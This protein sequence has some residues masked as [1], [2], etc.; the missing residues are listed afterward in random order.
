MT[1][2]GE[3]P[4]WPRLDKRTGDKPQNRR[5]A[6]TSKA[7]AAGRP[8]AS[9]R[10]VKLGRD[11]RIATAHATFSV[12]RAAAAGAEQRVVV[13]AR[14][15]EKADAAGLQAVLAGR[16]EIVRAGKD[17]AWSEA[18]PQLKA[19]AELLGLQQA[20]GLAP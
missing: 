19:A 18:T 14:Q 17:L 12:L 6:K 5:V 20:L 10:T 15:V 7:T 9:T 8:A 11:L 13:D 1:R 3:A 2:A 16:A 4:H